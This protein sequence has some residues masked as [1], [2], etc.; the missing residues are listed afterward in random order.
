VAQHIL[1]FEKPV[2]DLEKKIE[3]MRTLAGTLDISDQISDLEGK[4]EELRLD[5]YSNLTRWQRIQIA[6][7]P[8]RPYTLDY[9]LNTFSNFT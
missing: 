9:C 6:R 2:I 1:D 7:H 5:I 8:D 4:I 3:E